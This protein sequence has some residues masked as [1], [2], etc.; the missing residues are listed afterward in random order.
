MSNIDQYLG[1]G[2]TQTGPGSYVL[3][4]TTITTGQNSFR[5]TPIIG[6]NYDD[7]SKSP[8][9]RKVASGF[10]REV[11]DKYKVTINQEVA[12]QEA[13]YAA[14]R[15]LVPADIQKKMEED[16]RSQ[17]V[18]L[19]DR[20]ANLVSEITTLDNVISQAS[21]DIASLQPV[22]N[23]FFK[24]D[25]FGQPVNAFLEVAAM[26]LAYRIDLPEYSYADW[27]KSLKAAYEVKRLNAVVELSNKQKAWLSQQL[28]QARLAA[29]ANTFRAPGSVSVARPLF[30]TSAG[31][32]AVVE[33][34]AI[35]LQTAI[36]AA[37][38]AL[39]GLVASVGA[40]F[41]VGV[42][43]LFYSSKLANGELP[44]RY[45]FRT[46][47]SDLAPELSLPALQ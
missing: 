34:A 9:G 29:N 1:P 26:R 41:A 44:E 5:L 2:W 21:V 28:E 37:I 18:Q 4:T 30:M 38:T 22:A 47:L 17:G 42:S 36:R 12:A 19:Q 10:R 6:S 27:Q 25:F 32:V 46:P 20:V 15:Q 39:G 33:T 31:T 14:K 13:D 40:G 16:K 23:S 11:S 24:G 35:T 8:V 43:A 45:A 7:F 3:P